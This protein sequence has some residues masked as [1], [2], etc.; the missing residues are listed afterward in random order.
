MSLFIGP[1][2]K[3]VNTM[4]PSGMVEAPKKVVLKSKKLDALKAAEAP[5]KVVL[6]SKKLDAEKKAKAEKPEAKMLKEIEDLVEEM[7]QMARE[8]EPR[9]EV[10]KVWNGE[11]TY[12]LNLYGG[13]YLPSG[14]ASEMSDA[15]VDE[16]NE[17][18]EANKKPEPE[19]KYNF[20]A[21]K[22]TFQ[23]FKKQTEKIVKEGIEMSKGKTAFTGKAKIIDK[24]VSMLESYSALMEK[25]KRMPSGK[26]NPEYDDWRFD[27][28]WDFLSNIPYNWKV[29]VFKKAGIKEAKDEYSGT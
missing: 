28:D 15:W 4:G 20:E 16:I 8:G 7:K 19:R 27:N 12:L 6:K 24:L 25:M 29:M 22:D 23:A 2:G 13:E 21:L 17:L 1:T 11:F 14:A 18:L 26:W 10:A 9:S 5:K 3:Y